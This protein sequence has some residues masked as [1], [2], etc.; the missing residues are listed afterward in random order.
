MYIYFFPTSETIHLGFS[1]LTIN[2]NIILNSTYTT[3]KV[4]IT[5]NIESNTSKGRNINKQNE[6][7]I[8]Q[9]HEPAI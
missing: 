9:K 3:L 5:I 7:L 1:S 6:T 4:K 8:R 2:P